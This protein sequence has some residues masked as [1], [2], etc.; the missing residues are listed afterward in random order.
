M[1]EVPLTFDCPPNKIVHFKGEKT[2]SIVT[3]KNDQNSFTCVL[4]CAANKQKLIFK[5]KTNPK[6][7]FTNYATVTMNEK[8]WMC[9]GVIIE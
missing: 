6:V 2:V 9:E 3:M 8:G 5:R 7:N 1:D 4:S